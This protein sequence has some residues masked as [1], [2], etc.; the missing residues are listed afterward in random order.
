MGLQVRSLTA[1]KVSGKLGPP[2]FRAA[3]SV[4][5]EFR[6]S[7]GGREIS[8]EIHVEDKGQT[9][10]LETKIPGDGERPGRTIKRVYRKEG[11]S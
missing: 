10:V 4:R 5:R 9:L 7:A 3:S 2:S 8:Q 6:L 1:A 11:A